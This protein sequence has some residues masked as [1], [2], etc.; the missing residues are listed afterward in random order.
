[1]SLTISTSAAAASIAIA[2]AFN[3][4]QDVAWSLQ[5]SLCGSVDAQAGF[6][7]FLYDAPALTNGGIGKSLGFAPSQDYT[8][9]TNISG[10]SGAII[11]IGFDSTGLFAASGNECLLA[12]MHHKSFPMQSQYAQEPILHMSPHLQLLLS[13][14]HSL[15]CNHLMHCSNFDSD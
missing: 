12:L 10:V 8:S 13:I 11:G 5:Y 15:W 7:A 1:M 2:Q 6:C 14:L 3:A 9:F 4:Y